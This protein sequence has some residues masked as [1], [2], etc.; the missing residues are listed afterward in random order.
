MSTSTTKI[1]TSVAKF[2]EF[3]S[4]I[5]KDQLFETL[6]K[7]PDER[8]LEIDYNNLEMF[9]P[10]LADLLIDKPQ[11]ILDAATNA[12]KN[13]DPLVKD[14][15]INLRIANLTNIIPL[16]TL[17]SKYIG[18]FVA[19]DGIVRKTDEIRPRIETVIM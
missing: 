17:L 8:S 16:K 15:D 9:D 19:A 11:E 6:E 12:I 13:I 2:E 3:F 1:G 14:V 5:Y 18:N 10:D 4:T 7:Y